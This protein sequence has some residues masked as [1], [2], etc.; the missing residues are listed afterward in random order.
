ME[1]ERL[2]IPI[3]ENPTRQKAWRVAAFVVPLLFLALITAAVFRLI[4]T[5]DTF[6]AAW[7]ISATSAVRII[8]TT[9]DARI[10]DDHFHGRLLNEDSPRTVDQVMLSAN[11]EAI[12][13]FHG[14]SVIGALADTDTYIKSF[15][16]I[17][18]SLLLPWYEGE[19]LVKD[20]SQVSSLPLDLT[21]ESLTIH[22]IS[23]NN[24]LPVVSFKEGTTI[25]A[26]L[27]LSPDEASSFL[28]TNIPLVYPGTAAI[29]KEAGEKGIAVLFGE[30]ARGFVYALSIENANISRDDLESF[31]EESLLTPSIVAEP[32]KQNGATAYTELRSDKDIVVSTTA[33]TTI[34]MTTARSKDGEVVRATQTPHGLVLSNRDVQI[35]TSA[36]PIP[37]ACLRGARQFVLPSKLSAFLPKSALIT[38]ALFENFFPQ[39]KEIAF[40]NNTMRIC[41]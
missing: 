31:V 30:D 20:G 24:D 23:R 14:D 12:I 10:I 21:N 2:D 39:T 8:K 22:G 1:T 41:W 37:D 3:H 9:E 18:F 15:P 29:F 33:D 34:T 25:S 7:P 35:N 17:S 11:R 16:R 4:L 19:I 36:P 6:A 28:P 38:S 40:K 26:S 27:N 32:F 13:F 5:R